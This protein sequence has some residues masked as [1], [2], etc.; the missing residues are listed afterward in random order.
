MEKPIGAMLS[1][2]GS[3]CDQGRQQALVV[4]A[5]QNHLLSMFYLHLTSESRKK[6]LLIAA[7]ACNTAPSYN[8]LMPSNHQGLSFQGA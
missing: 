2:D 3:F 5:L 6:W 4:S 7:Q 8:T 1:R